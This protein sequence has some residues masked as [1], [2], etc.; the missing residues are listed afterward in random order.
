[1]AGVQAEILEARTLAEGKRED[2]SRLSQT[3]QKKSKAFGREKLAAIFER[4]T[5]RMHNLSEFI[6]EA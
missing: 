6:A 4:Y 3:D 1:M 2:F 5:K